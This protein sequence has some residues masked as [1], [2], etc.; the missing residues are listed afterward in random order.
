MKKRTKSI[1][2]KLYILSG[3]AAAVALL[4]A[5]VAFSY[6]NISTYRQNSV[7]RMSSVG[8]IV[9]ANTLAAITFDDHVTA[10][11]VLAS[12]ERS[13]DVTAAC[14]IGSDGEIFASYTRPGMENSFKLPITVSSGH[15]FDASGELDVFIPI[16]DGDEKHG[17]LFLHST[18]EQLNRSLMKFAFNLFMVFI[19]SLAAAISFSSRLQSVIATPIKDLAETAEMISQNHDYSIRVQSKSNDEIGILFEAFNDMLTQIETSE[20]K[21]IEARNSL[22][23]RVGDRTKE[24]TISH[25]QLTSKMEENQK[26][27]RRLIDASRQA[28]KAEVASGVLH[29]VGNVL[30]SVNVSANVVLSQI[31]KSRISDL[32]RLNGVVKEHLDDLPGF[33]SSKRGQLLPVMLEQLTECLERENETLAQEV[34]SLQVNIDHIKKIVAAQQSYG[35][36]FGII[37]PMDLSEVFHECARIGGS[38][39]DQHNIQ[40][41]KQFEDIP[42]FACDRHQLMQILIN[43]IRNACQAVLTN[44]QADGIVTL[45]TILEGNFVRIQVADNGMGIAPDT[46][47][48]IFTHGFTTKADGHGFGLHSAALAT[49][50][51]GGSMRVDSEGLSLGATFTLRLPIQPKEAPESESNELDNAAPKPNSQPLDVR[52]TPTDSLTVNSD[53]DGTIDVSP[54]ANSSGD[55]PIFPTILTAGYRPNHTPQRRR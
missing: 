8:K 41:V 51:M 28:G 27:Q 36:S 4:F 29:N 30:N 23:I 50:E 26:M 10:A 3:S 9:A 24:L 5:S 11:E 39:V 49:K 53:T 31:K 12:L 34:C 1:R 37:E 47:T 19:F 42:C 2:G 16:S 44:G 21:L 32:I 17:T 25:I 54:D 22:E 15:Q 40:I 43:L 6:Q 13:H 33:V 55:S 52:V 7:D 18:M 45:R 20:H 46:L 35:N 38:S 48:K 14:I